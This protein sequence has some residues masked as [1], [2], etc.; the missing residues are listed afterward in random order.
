MHSY[1]SSTQTEVRPCHAVGG[2]NHAAMHPATVAEAL[3]AA[4]SLQ[5]TRPA[6]GAL[7][8]LHLPEQQRDEAQS[9]LHT[10]AWVSA[11]E[12]H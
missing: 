2:L 5:L 9:R 1:Q 6:A 8:L 10:C 12:I 4:L 11:H 3:A 7:S